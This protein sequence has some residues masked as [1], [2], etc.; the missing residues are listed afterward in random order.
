MVPHPPLRTRLASLLGLVLLAATPAASAAEPLNVLFVLLDDVGVD[1][2]GAW[3]AGPGAGP[4]PVIDALVAEGVAFRNA[5]AMPLCSPTRVSTLTG[6]LPGRT[7]VGDA[8]KWNGAAGPFT[9]DPGASVSLPEL[10][11]RSG[12]ATAAVGKWHICQESDDDPFGNPPTWGFDVHVGSIANMNY[13]GGDYFAWTQNTAWDGG[14][15]QEPAAGYLTTRQVDDALAAIDAFGDTP[16]FVWL[17]L[18]APHKPLHVPPDHLHTQGDL[19]GAGD[20]ELFRAVMEAADTELGRLLASLP[21]QTRQRTVVIVMG[22]NGT[23]KSAMEPPFGVDKHHKNHVY[24]GGTNVPLVVAGPGVASGWSD[25]LVSCTDI[26]ATVAELAGLSVPPGSA[27]DSLSFARSLTD[28]AG[29]GRRRT[30]V[31]EKF[32]PNGFGLAVDWQKAARDGRY[33]LVRLNSFTQEF[34]DLQADPHEQD[35]L[36]GLGTPPLT[37]PQQAAF[38]KLIQVLAAAP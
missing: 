7:G 5:S 3:G 33:K 34:Y 6:R 4:T 19:E 30:M 13:D 37:A 10:V 36:L 20:P 9:P 1:K 23:Y 32:T 8:V 31:V 21:R 27:E 12:W 14:H 15:A 11:S 18:S 16:W 35:N 22:D 25:A 26:Y 2:V 29:P 17:A 24:E 28:P 38:A